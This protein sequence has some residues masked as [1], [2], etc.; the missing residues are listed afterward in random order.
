ML[1]G[2]RE[3]FSRPIEDI[4]SE[5][6]RDRV[7][8]FGAVPIAEAPRRRPAVLVGEVQ[9]LQVVP[10]AG[11]TSLEVTIDDGTARAVAVFTGRS[12][13]GGVSVGRRVVLEGV[14]R[15]EHGRLVILNPAYT[16]VK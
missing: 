1:K 3:K 16:I 13:L 4:E 15:D 8:D 12:R 9:G 5:R 14:G 2:L 6:L 11:G 7:E 10:R